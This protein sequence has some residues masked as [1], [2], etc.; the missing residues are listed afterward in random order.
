M[1]L[2]IH[3]VYVRQRIFSFLSVLFFLSKHPSDKEER[4]GLSE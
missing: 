1:L 3:F 4:E 2:K